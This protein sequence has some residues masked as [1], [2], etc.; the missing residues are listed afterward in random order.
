[1]NTD[2]ITEAMANKWQKKL[3]QSIVYY[4]LDDLK[5]LLLKRHLLL[6]RNE[7]TFKGTFSLDFTF[8]V[9]ANDMLLTDHSPVIMAILHNQTEALRLLLQAGASPEFAPS[10]FHKISRT[11]LSRACTT[12]NMEMI[13]LLLHHG[14]NIN[15]KPAGFLGC[16]ALEYAFS[17]EDCDAVAILLQHGAYL[18]PEGSQY[19]DFW[20]SAMFGEKSA[21]FELLLDNADKHDIAVPHTFI[22]GNSHLKYSHRNIKV[23]LGRGYFPSDASK[24]LDIFHI[25]TKISSI[26]TTNMMLAQAPM[27]LHSNMAE[28]I[29]NYR[30]LRGG[31]H[32]SVSEE[33]VAWM[34]KAMLC[35]PPL[36]H[37]CK[38]CIITAVGQ[39]Y[40]GKMNQLRLPKPLVLY[41]QSLE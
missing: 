36:Q 7:G 3:I 39:R 13:N 23:M 16:T 29:V 37:Q 18:S 8:K 40:M 26:E 32:S 9:N 33:Y 34:K 20:F 2:S 4:N 11:P 15:A 21:I 41:L 5:D 27:L 24:R 6:D 1:M 31:P 25:V 17:D 38:A 28:W 12:G 10:A 14:A 22:F 19:K 35:C 30:L